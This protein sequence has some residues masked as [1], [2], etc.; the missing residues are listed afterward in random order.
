MPSGAHLRFLQPLHPPRTSRGDVS[1]QP[2]V[3]ERSGDTPGYR[4]LAPRPRQ[5]AWI[6]RPCHRLALLA[7]CLS[8][9]LSP[10]GAVAHS[11]LMAGKPPAC[12][13]SGPEQ[14]RT[15]TVQ[16]RTETEQRWIGMGVQPCR[17]PERSGGLRQ[18]CRCALALLRRRR[19][20]KVPAMKTSNWSTAI[21]SDLSAAS[22]KISTRVLSTPP[23]PPH[24]WG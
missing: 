24:I 10:G 12:K 6:R 11:R 13:M 5:G 16:N 23:L 19:A 14:N 15:K 4:G 17:R 9:R 22:S 3:E 21:P 8:P 2:G 18:G 20:G 1:H 7:G